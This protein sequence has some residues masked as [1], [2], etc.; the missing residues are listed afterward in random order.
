MYSIDGSQLGSELVRAAIWFLEKLSV[1]RDPNEQLAGGNEGGQL[2]GTDADLDYQ[3]IAEDSNLNT[4]TESFLE[5]AN[6]RDTQADLSNQHPEVNITSTTSEMA[7]TITPNLM[8]TTMPIGVKKF[9]IELDDIQVA[10]NPQL[11]RDIK[12][13]FPWATIEDKPGPNISRK[14]STVSAIENEYSNSI[15]HDPVE[16]LTDLANYA[17]KLPTEDEFGYKYPLDDIWELLPSVRKLEVAHARAIQGKYGRSVDGTRCSRCVSQDYECKVYGPQPGDTTLKSFFGTSC[18]NCRLHGFECVFPIAADVHCAPHPITHGQSGPQPGTSDVSTARALET[19]RT[20]SAVSKGESSLAENIPCESN[21]PEAGADIEQDE[22]SLYRETRRRHRFPNIAITNMLPADAIIERAELLNFELNR[23]VRGLLHDM[24]TQWIDTEMINPFNNINPVNGKKNRL[25]DFYKSLMTL[26]I[27]AH[28]ES[29]SDLCYAV[30]LRFQS[31]NCRELDGFP[32]VET[33]VLAFEHL[34]TH[35]P[36]CEWIAILFAYLWDTVV[37]G[38]YET[39]VTKRPIL[40]P[41]AFSKLLYAIAYIRDPYTTGLDSAVLDGWCDVHD[42]PDKDSPAN[43]ACSK[44]R[45]GLTGKRKQLAA[46]ESSSNKNKRKAEESLAQPVQKIK[47]GRG[48]PRK[49]EAE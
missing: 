8:E 46:N 37:N 31:T 17:T 35:S 48:R 4:G 38:K 9:S 15:R 21:A 33:A 2:Y 40:D 22:N 26:Y 34:P 16:L 12:E 42:H 43:F 44:M 27:V 45:S 18:Q 7:S 10:R 32:M 24:Y 3:T 30:L 25:Q 1:E 11:A 5:D 49:I 14:R 6:T 19:P 41:T 13:Q 20:A 23:T 36:L 47:R 29:Q 28:K 39:F